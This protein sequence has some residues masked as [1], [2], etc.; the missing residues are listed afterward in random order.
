MLV[1]FGTIL[2]AAAASSQFFF[3]VSCNDFQLPIFEVRSEFIMLAM[4][5]S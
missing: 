1:L 5:V 2:L 3:P 4:C